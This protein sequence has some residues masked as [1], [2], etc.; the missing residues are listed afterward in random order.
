MPLGVG[1]R[2]QQRFR[3]RKARGE[4]RQTKGKERDGAK[5]LSEHG[6]ILDFVKIHYIPMIIEF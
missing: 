2:N 3:C 6:I 1:F 5:M 4:K